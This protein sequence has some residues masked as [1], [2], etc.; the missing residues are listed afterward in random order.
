MS[1]GLGDVYKRQGR[2]VAAGAVGSALLMAGHALVPNTPGRL[3]SLL[4]TFLPWLG[5][6]VPVGLVLAAVR[7]SRAAAVAVLLPAAV[8]AAVFGGTLPDRSGS[9]GDLRVVSHNVDEANRDPR[10]TARA[11][12]ASGA[13]VV[14]L[15]EL[16]ARGAQSYGEVLD[17]VFPYHRVLGGVGMWSRYPLRD[18]LPVE[19]MPWV[20][21]MRATVDTPRGPLALYA[22]HLASVRVSA[23]SGFGTGQRDEAARRL[24]AAVRA[25]PSERVVVVGD[26]NGSTRDR[27]LAGALE[28]LR[29]AQDA[30]GDGFGLSWPAAFPLVRIDQILV[31]GVTPVWARTLPR[32]GS[33]HLPVE[34]SVRW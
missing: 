13:D 5:L 27:T 8:W 9:G 14:A 2:V 31:R 1:R 26:F 32:T 6:A 29:S 18:V 19:I 24:A 20:R 17:G 28:G 22:A 34:A 21:A 16:P 33:D 23:L 11:L 30:A 7:R 3:G 10:G 12:A 25:E 4:E 15:Q